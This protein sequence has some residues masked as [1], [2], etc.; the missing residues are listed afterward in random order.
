MADLCCSDLAAVQ[1]WVRQHGGAAWWQRM[2]VTLGAY[3][4]SLREIAGFSLRVVEGM[5]DI[6][7]G[8]L[9]LL[10]HDRIKSPSPNVLAAL[11]KCYGADY[12]ALMQLAGYPV[13]GSPRPLPQGTTFFHGV[14]QLTSAEREEIQEIIAL[15]LRLRRES[16]G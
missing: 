6:S 8:Y 10:E 5:T 16:L 15:K 12:G 2:T 4:K 3:L 14:E 11:A 13:P 1:W 9:S 7:N